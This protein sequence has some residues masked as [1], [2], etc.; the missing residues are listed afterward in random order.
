[1]GGPEKAEDRNFPWPITRS[2]PLVTCSQFWS[3]NSACLVEAGYGRTGHTPHQVRMPPSGR[4]G[5]AGLVNFLQRLSEDTCRRRRAL[6]SEWGWAVDI[7]LTSW[8]FPSCCSSLLT[9][10]HL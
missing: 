2:G 3:M 1:M 5:D 7:G 6:A 9:V 4:G 8:T 10:L